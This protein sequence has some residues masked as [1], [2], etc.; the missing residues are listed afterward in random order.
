MPA[1]RRG[2]LT[3]PDLVL[4]RLLS[5]QPMH[6]HE[7]N[8]ELERRQVSDWADI[9]RPTV[10]WSLKKL[11]RRGLICTTKGSNKSA[12]RRRQ[13]FTPTPKSRAAFLQAMNYDYWPTQRGRSEFVTWF[14]L[15]SPMAPACFKRQLRSRE[16]FLREHLAREESRLRRILR[17]NGDRFSEVVWVI[18]FLIDECRAEL[19]WLHKLSR[20]VR[21][22]I[23]LAVARRSDRI[24]R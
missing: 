14:A 2:D 15:S 18:R 4:L 3:L 13:V 10:Y 17:E 23:P 1:F 19:R 5:E 12:R 7:A 8:L 24:P 20:E 11:V 6:G 21:H 22:R 9:S 16:K